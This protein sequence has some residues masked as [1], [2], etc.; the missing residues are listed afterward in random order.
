MGGLL[1]VAL[2]ALGSWLLVGKA[3][4]LVEHKGKEHAMKT[5][6]ELEVWQA[7]YEMALAIY[8]LTDLFPASERFGLTAQLQRSAVSAPSNIAEGHGRNRNTE[9]FHFCEIAMGSTCEA[10]CQLLIA[11][12]RHYV[13]D[14]QLSPVMARVH[15]TK[16]LLRGFMAYLQR[17]STP[18]P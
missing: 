18:G 17:G 7:A 12:G 14:E 10:E 13:T 8:E 2:L 9:F 4:L 3:S 15:K 16:R 1:S 5:F 11:H 6:Q